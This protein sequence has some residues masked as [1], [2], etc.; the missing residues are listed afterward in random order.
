MSRVE[1]ERAERVVR[2]GGVAVVDG[3]AVKELE[4]YLMAHERE[5]RESIEGGLWQDYR[6]RGKEHEE[7]QTLVFDKQGRI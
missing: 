4:P 7:K 1:G 5:L 2:N 6:W 3:I